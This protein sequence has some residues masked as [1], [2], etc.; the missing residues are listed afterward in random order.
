M[1]LI[2]LILITY[3]ASYDINITVS[4]SE[5]IIKWIVWIKLSCI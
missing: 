2:E 3:K 1:A 5:H 4:L